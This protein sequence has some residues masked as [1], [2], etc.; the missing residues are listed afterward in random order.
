MNAEKFMNSALNF[1]KGPLGIIALFIV[2]VY[3]MASLVALFTKNPSIDIMPLIYF[4]VL[5][6]VAVY[7]G[8]LWLV[9]NH[10]EKLY[11]PSDFKDEENFIKAHILSITSLYQAVAIKEDHKKEISLNK[12]NEMIDRAKNTSYQETLNKHIT[13]ILWVDDK[14]DNNFYE[15]SA[16][17]ALGFECIIKESTDDAL[18]IIKKESYTV[19]ISDMCRKE[20]EVEGY[21]FL[22]KVKEL[23]VKIPFIIYTGKYNEKMRNE[24]IE[25]GAALLTSNPEELFS[26]I[27]NVVNRDM[28]RLSK[29][30]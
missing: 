24:V 14:P 7:M 16:F 20:S 18:E 5:F 22:E 26:T 10:H 17:E 27:L 25:K 30:A 13:K 21:I 12:I 29:K 9:S 19:I 28:V 6:P 1:T 8:F 23:G 2:L 11:S 15:R 3:A 4:M